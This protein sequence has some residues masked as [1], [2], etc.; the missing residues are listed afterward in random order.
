MFWQTFIYEDVRIIT[1]KR[2]KSMSELEKEGQEGG[3]FYLLKEAMIL[4]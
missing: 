4:Q 2:I 1:D 3:N